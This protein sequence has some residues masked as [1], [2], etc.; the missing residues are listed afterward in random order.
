MLM[1]IETI[2]IIATGSNC[3]FEL[4]IEL[5]SRANTEHTR[6]APGAQRAP[7]DPGLAPRVAPEATWVAR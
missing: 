5:P 3:N 2:T 1:I 7:V 4:E 6:A